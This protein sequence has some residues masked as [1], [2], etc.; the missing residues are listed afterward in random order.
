MAA[1]SALQL[2]AH[3]SCQSIAAV[4]IAAVVIAAVVFVC[5]L[6]FLFFYV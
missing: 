3:G 6:I 1:V 4:V 2:S 5:L